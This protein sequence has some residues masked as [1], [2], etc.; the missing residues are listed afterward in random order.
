[1]IMFVNTYDLLSNSKWDIGTRIASPTSIQ[2][3]KQMRIL[4]VENEQA[5]LGRP[6]K[7]GLGFAILGRERGQAEKHYSCLADTSRG[8]IGNLTRL[9][10]ILHTYILA[11][12][13]PTVE[14][15]S[16]RI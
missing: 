9:I 1:M 8:L 7:S 4:S 13:S 10:H 15:K 14:E 11:A 16:E 2:L 3:L 6:A 12:T 5:N